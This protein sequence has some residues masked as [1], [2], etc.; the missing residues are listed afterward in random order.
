MTEVEV[1]VGV[2]RAAM[3]AP[4]AEARLASDPSRM[5]QRG[6]RRTASLSA[7]VAVPHGPVVET[8]RG[9]HSLNPKQLDRFRLSPAS[10]KDDCRDARALR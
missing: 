8:E 10:A 3:P 5:G 6:W 2:G 9:F 4:A 1:F 7:L